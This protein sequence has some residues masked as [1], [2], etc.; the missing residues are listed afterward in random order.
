M[1]HYQQVQSVSEETCT[2]K[3][4]HISTCLLSRGE[5]V[6]SK[7]KFLCEVKPLN[8]PLNVESW[9]KGRWI[10]VRQFSFSSEWDVPLWFPISFS[11]SFFLIYRIC[12]GSGNAR[13][14]MC[15]NWRA[16]QIDMWM[17]PSLSHWKMYGFIYEMLPFLMSGHRAGRCASN[18]TMKLS[19]YSKRLS[20]HKTVCHNLW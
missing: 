6:N 16:M 14:E 5:K 13:R 3:G 20:V 17:A 9:G 7:I 2:N 15:E 10:C 11:I 4:W 8:T 18:W 19:N 12:W 1:Y